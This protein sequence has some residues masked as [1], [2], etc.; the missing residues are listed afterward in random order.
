VIANLDAPSYLT[1]PFARSL[2]PC[3][4]RQMS[5]NVPFEELRGMAAVWSVV[6]S[7]TWVSF[8]VL[9]VFVVVVVLWTVR[10]R[11]GSWR[12]RSVR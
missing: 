1:V 3:L 12:L 11:S 10:L 2:A 8:L 4:L 7:I 9:L 6:R 5:S